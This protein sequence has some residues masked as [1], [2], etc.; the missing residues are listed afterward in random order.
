MVLVESLNV[1]LPRSSAA[2][3]I[4]LSPPSRSLKLQLIDHYFSCDS[5]PTISEE[6]MLR[7]FMEPKDEIEAK[8]KA[9]GR[10]QSDILRCRWMDWDI[11]K[12]HTEAFL[13]RVIMREFE[14]HHLTW[15]DGSVVCESVVQ[16]FVRS[17]SESSASEPMNWALKLTEM[18]RM[19]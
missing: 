14:R 2:I 11:V 8:F 19:N 5:D 12:V 17:V 3:G 15:Q 9:K 4:A 13:T 16:S 10:A 18:T 7:D 6:D 1:N